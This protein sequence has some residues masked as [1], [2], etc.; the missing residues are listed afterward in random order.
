LA[1]KIKKG[2]PDALIIVGGIHPSVDPKGVMANKCFDILVEGEGETALLKIIEAIYSAADIS[3]ISGIYFRNHEGEPVYTGL[4]ELMNIDELP[5]DI[6][7]EL[8]LAS[9]DLAMEQFAN[10]RFLPIMA[11]RGCAFRCRFCSYPSI[12]SR[13]VRFKSPERL[14]QEIEGYVNKYGV[15][16]FFFNDDTFVLDRDRI[17]SFCLFFFVRRHVNEDRFFHFYFRWAFMYPTMEG[18]SSGANQRMPSIFRNHV[19]C[20]FA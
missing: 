19:I 2:K 7:T 14:A 20:L 16:N 11:S 4:G 10:E 8:S 18:K 9:Y 12:I 5:L 6:F 3:E 15:Y 13:R 1:G 17:F